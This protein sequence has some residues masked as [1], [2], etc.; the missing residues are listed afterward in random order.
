[1]KKQTG[2][3]LIELMIA[4]VLGLF[5]MGGVIQVLT[6]SQGSYQ[7]ITSQARMQESAKIALDYLVRDLRNVGYWGCSGQA[8]NVANTVVGG[9]GYDP[10]NVLRGWDDS[11]TKP[12]PYDGNIIS[13]TDVIEMSIVDIEKGLSLVEQKG[14]GT[15]GNAS[16]HLNADHDGETDD[17]WMIVD[18]DCSNIAILAQSSD[19]GQASVLVHNKAKGKVEEN[20]TMAIRGNFD[21][22]DTTGALGD[23]YQKGSSVYK[24]SNIAYAIQDGENG[25]KALRRYSDSTS[26][27]SEKLMEGVLDLDFTYGVDTT[28]DGAVDRFANASVL[29]NA[30]SGLLWKDVISISI[31]LVVINPSDNSQTE[32]FSTSVRLR[33]RGI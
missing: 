10:D 29:N 18:V 12:A 24:F 9:S 32:T 17:I 31:D 11:E 14:G 30:A 28:G 22:S 13:G 23:N 15:N 4:L 5:L 26:D 21:C 7:D 16:L 1:M 19:T 20:C 33:N 25:L 27:D 8:V 2:L 6:S 3:S